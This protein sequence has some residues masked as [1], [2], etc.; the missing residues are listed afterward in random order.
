MVGSEELF[1]AGVAEGKE[2]GLE[3]LRVC[4]GCCD[5]SRWACVADWRPVCGRSG[6]DSGLSSS[7][8]DLFAHEVIRASK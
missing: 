3:L 4:E 5:G 7:I 1:A 8:V 2:G 6:D